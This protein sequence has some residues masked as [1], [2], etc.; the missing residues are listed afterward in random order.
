MSSSNR[1]ERVEEIHAYYDRLKDLIMSMDNDSLL[2]SPARIAMKRIHLE[3]KLDILPEDYLREALRHVERIVTH[4]PLKTN[5]DIEN[6]KKANSEFSK[7]IWISGAKGVGKL[8]ASALLELLTFALIAASIITIG[9]LALACTPVLMIP[10]IL[11]GGLLAAAITAPPAIFGMHV[12]SSGR[13]Q[14][15]SAF[16][17]HGLYAAGQ[18]QITA[19]VENAQNLAAQPR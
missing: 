18:K 9:F 12:Y 19:A 10:I 14:L 2:K 6:F 17:Q 11:G 15:S 13:H 7:F 3:I 4:P 5:D 16:M 1:N 8:F